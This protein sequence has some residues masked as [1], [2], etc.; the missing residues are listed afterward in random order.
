MGT[1]ARA[2]AAKNRLITYLHS[3]TQGTCC[4]SATKWDPVIIR[5]LTDLL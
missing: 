5:R 4:I 2:N 1:H 3:S